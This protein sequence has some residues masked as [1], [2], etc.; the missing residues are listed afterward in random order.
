MILRLTSYTKKSISQTKELIRNLHISGGSLGQRA[1]RGGF[2]V[3]LSFG[4]K[5][6]LGI[7]RSIILAR[8]LL[9][10]D[11]G[12]MGLALVATGFLTVM[13][14][15]GVAPALIHRQDDADDTLNTA[16]TISIL[17]SALLF[18]ITFLTAGLVASFFEAPELAPILRVMA[19]TFLISGLRN[20]GAI[21]LNKELE[22][23]TLAYFNLTSTVLSL[24]VVIAAAFILRNVWAL[25]LGTLIEALIMLVG[26]YVIH[27]FRPR[28]RWVPQVA[29]GMLN[30]GKYIFGGAIVNYLLTQGDDALIG[31]VLGTAQLG[32]YVIAYNL[33]NIAT[34]SITH[35]IGQVAFPAYAKLQ[36][37]IPALR[38]AY[39][40][41]LKVTGLMAIP[42]TAGLFALAYELVYVIYGE[43]WVPMV[44]ALMVLCIYGLERA[45][46]A[47]VGALFK[48]KGKPQVVLYLT[49]FKLILLILI[50]YPLTIRYGILGT[51]IASALV[52]IVISMNAMPLVARMLECSV[53][54]ILKPLT[55]PSIAAV[56]M[57][58]TLFSLKFTGW[59]APN[60]L[61]L[62]IL[63]VI[64]A[65]VY[66]LGLYVFDRA[67]FREIRQLI[68]SQLDASEASVQ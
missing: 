55:G 64:G 61:S 31:K 66:V 12:L 35:V 32:F 39:L 37:D 16:W 26:S 60:I 62:I 17:R 5:K 63:I 36:N 22:F 14:E 48:S 42:V 43:K 1:V 19:F 51:S 10:S 49:S 50:I 65:L 40:R 18:A 46:N 44:P 21:M 11:F 27:P 6:F 52:A 41:T 30:Y 56:I 2:W 3:F 8:L 34:T 53:T 68:G 20:I 24:I 9:P 54:V 57:V 45:L 7:I 59:F 29:K 38:H 15:V 58:L 23:R 28:L 33:S 13:T 47:S 4:G 67:S 25:V